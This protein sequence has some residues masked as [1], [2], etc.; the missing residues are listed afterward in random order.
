MVSPGR[1]SRQLRSSW[2]ASLAMTSSPSDVSVQLLDRGAVPVLVDVAQ[3]RPRPRRSSSGIG[4]PLVT[5]SSKHT[6]KYSS[7]A[8]PVVMRSRRRSSF[9]S[10]NHSAAARSWTAWSTMTVVHGGGDVGRRVPGRSTAGWTA[11]AAPAGSRMRL[12][13]RRSGPPSEPLSTST[14]G[15][16]ARQAWSMTA[17][18]GAA[19]AVVVNRVLGAHPP[20]ISGKESWV[21]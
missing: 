21:R 12:T 2:R 1:T 19:T 11:A 15:P 20:R 16:I 18:R 13:V 5:A 17:R 14:P 3:H 7:W 10:A 8:F 6:G 9:S 4:A